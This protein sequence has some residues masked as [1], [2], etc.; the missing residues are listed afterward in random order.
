MRPLTAF[1]F[2]DG[3]VRPLRLSCAPPAARRPVTREVDMIVSRSLAPILREM[4]YRG[5]LVT[6]E[7]LM[8]PEHLR[9]K[10]HGRTVAAR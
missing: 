3:T 1:L 6:T 7:S 9:A 4:G 2:R 10:H 5:P 8:R